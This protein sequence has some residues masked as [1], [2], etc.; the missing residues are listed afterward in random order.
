[1]ALGYI[2]SDVGITWNCDLSPCPHPARQ[3]IT[4]DEERVL[5]SL[6]RPR[7]VR[8]SESSLKSSCQ[9]SVDS[10]QLTD[11]TGRTSCRKSL[12]IKSMQLSV[13]ESRACS[14]NLRKLMI[15]KNNHSGGGRGGPTIMGAWA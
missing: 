5:V 8:R 15:L 4:G 12:R 6:L 10:C 9:W 14:L 7:P 11:S 13:Y 3:G 1:M 2:T